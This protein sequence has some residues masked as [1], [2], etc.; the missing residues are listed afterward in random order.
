MPN[1]LEL[2]TGTDFIFIDANIFLFH[3]FADPRYGATAKK[4]LQKVGADTIQAVTSALVLNEV[5]FKIAHEEAK[6]HVSRATL[7]NVKN[8]LKNDPT[9]R[10]TIY[11]P[12]KTYQ[13]YINRLMLTGLSVVE[14]STSQTAQAVDIGRQHGLL[15]TDATHIA[16]MQSLRLTHLATGDADMWNILGITAWAP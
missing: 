9:F 12:V 2:Y 14:V 6:L 4:F 10:H 15:I 13:A 3:V 11:T 5:F 8:R 1:R 7:W 16:V